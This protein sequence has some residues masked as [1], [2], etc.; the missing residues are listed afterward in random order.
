MFN[1][2]RSVALLVVHQEGLTVSLDRKT[3]ALFQCLH[4]HSPEAEPGSNFVL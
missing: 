2:Y 4:Q 1:F 3:A